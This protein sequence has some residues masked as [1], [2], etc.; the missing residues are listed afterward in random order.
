MIGELLNC[1][2]CVMP[3]FIETYCLAFAEAMM[4]GVPVV[5]SFAGAMPELA[6]HNKEA[7][8]YNPLDHI[9]CAA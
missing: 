2:V 6:E 5:V 8:F 4:V 1:N 9:T 3:S 7:M